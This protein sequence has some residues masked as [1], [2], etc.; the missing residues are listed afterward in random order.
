[1]LQLVEDDDHEEEDDDE[2]VLPVEREWL[3]QD[4]DWQENEIRQVQENVENLEFHLEAQKLIKTTKTRFKRLDCTAHVADLS[5]FS[6]FIYL[7]FIL[8]FTT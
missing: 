7:Y 6:L 2:E 1:M 5:K 4:G 3:D 8:I